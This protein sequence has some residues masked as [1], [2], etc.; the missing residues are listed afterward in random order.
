MPTFKATATAKAHPTGKANDFPNLEFQT[1]MHFRINWTFGLNGPAF[2]SIK[3]IIG[4]DALGETLGK[5]LYSFEH[6]AALWDL[7][8]DQLEMEYQKTHRVEHEP[9]ADFFQELA[10]YFKPQ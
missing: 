8:G 3:P 7:F 2:S 6:D 4:E 5:E 1:L 10:G 9:V